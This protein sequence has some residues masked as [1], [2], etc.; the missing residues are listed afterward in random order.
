MVITLLRFQDATSTVIL[1]LLL[2]EQET[3]VVQGKNIAQLHFTMLIY[4]S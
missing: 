2:I 3:V 4:T 1:A